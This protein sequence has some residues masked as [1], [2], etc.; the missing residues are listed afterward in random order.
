[1]MIE[2]AELNAA[3]PA[4]FA[5]LLDGIFERS[6]WVAQVAVAARPFHS[7]EDLHA[8]LC[9][10]VNSATP[11]EQLA[12]IRAHPELA[13]RAAIR[14]ELTAESTHEQHGAGLDACTPQE[15]ERLQQLNA[16]YS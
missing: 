15:L 7:R 5:A 14:A 4:R 13:G 10:V 1:D 16:A 2:I 8:A 9:T 11:V 3:S 6:P 12:L